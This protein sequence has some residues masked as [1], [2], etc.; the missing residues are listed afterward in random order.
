M[1]P[2]EHH[3]AEYLLGLQR[4]PWLKGYARQCFAIWRE[5][6]GEHVVLRVKKI[7]KEKMGE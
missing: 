1:K 4:G 7:V 3:L 5:R 6:Y 2:I